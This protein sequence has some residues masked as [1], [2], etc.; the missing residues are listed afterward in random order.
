MLELTNERL[1]NIFLRRR[2]VS[3]L[4][5]AIVDQYNMKDLQD[6]DGLV[7]VFPKLLLLLQHMIAYDMRRVS[8]VP[9]NVHCVGLLSSNETR[10]GTRF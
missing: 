2:E 5:R 9:G 8:Y 6:C 4:V 1:A 3:A 10:F 7:A